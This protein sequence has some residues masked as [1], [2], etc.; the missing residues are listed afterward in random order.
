VETWIV[1]EQCSKCS[2]NV[3]CKRLMSKTLFFWV[4]FY[5]IN[6]WYCV[7]IFKFACLVINID[8]LNIKKIQN[9]LIG[10]N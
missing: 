8:L 2:G 7:N 10:N 4:S 5:D 9:S 6:I 1:I 3:D